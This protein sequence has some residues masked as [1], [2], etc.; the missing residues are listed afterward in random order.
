MSL[1]PCMSSKM[2]LCMFLGQITAWLWLALKTH[3]PAKAGDE[4]LITADSQ[5]QGKTHIPVAEF[6]ARWEKNGTGI[7]T[8]ATAW[9]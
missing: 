5:G 1:L 7:D 4:V 6:S 2:E 8:R 3:Y 9:S